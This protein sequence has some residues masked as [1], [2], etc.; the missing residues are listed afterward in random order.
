MKRLVLIKKGQKTRPKVSDRI[1]KLKTRQGRKASKEE[2]R[3]NVF[4]A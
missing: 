1:I 3:R 4:F 2:T